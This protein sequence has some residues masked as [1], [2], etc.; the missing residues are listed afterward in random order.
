MAYYHQQ[1]LIRIKQNQDTRNKR[2]TLRNF[3][4]LTELSDER[5]RELYHLPKSFVNELIDILKVH[6][7]DPQTA[8][9]TIQICTYT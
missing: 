4:P 9:G 5:F 7:K 3:N 8:E 1:Y 6:F 2:A